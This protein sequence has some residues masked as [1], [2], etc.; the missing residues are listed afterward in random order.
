TLVVA[1]PAFDHALLEIMSKYN[2][3]RAMLGRISRMAHILDEVRVYSRNIWWKLFFTA[4]GMDEPKDK[5]LEARTREYWEIVCEKMKLYPD[6]IETL[7][8]LRKK[9]IKLGIVTDTDGT[10]GLKYGRIKSLGIFDYFD[11]VVVAGEDTK[12]TKPDPE[13]FLLAARRLSVEPKECIMVG[14]K[15]F[16]DIEGALAAGMIAVYVKRAEWNYPNNAHYT[17]KNLKEI[18]SIIIQNYSG[19]G[20]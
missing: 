7:E 14:D 1:K 9:S 6:A 5:E 16:T 19:N 18:L 8:S 12:H 2:V 15:P 13:P 11:T 4:L 3:P 17:I 20:P 10:P